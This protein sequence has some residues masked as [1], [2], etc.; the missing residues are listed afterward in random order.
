MHDAVSY[1]SRKLK[2]KRWRDADKSL[3]RVE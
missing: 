1:M 3:R 2:G